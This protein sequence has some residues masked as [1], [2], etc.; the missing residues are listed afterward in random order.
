M[1][2]FVQK[3]NAPFIAKIYKDGRIGMW[4]DHHALLGE[5]TTI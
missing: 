1:Q 2:E 3:H 4:K 5:L